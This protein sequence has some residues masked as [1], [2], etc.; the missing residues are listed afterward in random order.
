MKDFNWYRVG[1]FSV[2]FTLFYFISIWIDPTMSLDSYT[3]QVVWILVAILIYE[4]K[5]DVRKLKN[6]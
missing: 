1:G 5:E 6:K 2:I 3:E 4:L